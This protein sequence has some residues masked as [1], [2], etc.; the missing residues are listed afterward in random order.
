MSGTK[1][2]GVVRMRYAHCCVGITE[3]Y[4]F[5]T[6]KHVVSGM[7]VPPTG[8]GRF[9]IPSMLVSSFVA[10]GGA[11]GPRELTV[12]FTDNRINILNSTTGPLEFKALEP[13]YPVT[14]HQALELIDTEIPGPGVY[15]F[16]F[17][18]DGVHVGRL[19]LMAVADTPDW[20]FPTDPVNLGRYARPGIMLDW[21]HVLDRV[22]Q[23][24]DGTITL[25]HVYEVWP[26]LS[27]P[28]SRS[29]S[30]VSLSCN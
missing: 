16:D 18:V 26:V 19:P 11:P 27:P 8:P 13:G 23:H 30:E 15:Y 10:H 25:H 24:A 29:R 5:A 20:K 14:A 22:E 7:V 28:P 12:S 2:S 21:G 1:A 3:A 6:L 17:I 9:P 4:M